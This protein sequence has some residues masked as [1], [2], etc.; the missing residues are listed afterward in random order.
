MIDQLSIQRGVTELHT[1]K[2]TAVSSSTQIHGSCFLI[3]LAGGWQW[4]EPSGWNLGATVTL[5]GI[6]VWSSGDRTDSAVATNN[7]AGTSTVVGGSTSDYQFEMDAPASFTMADARVRETWSLELD[8]TL[9][10]PTTA[11]NVLPGTTLTGA[12]VGPGNT[13]TNEQLDVP[14]VSNSWRCTLNGALGG[15]YCLSEHWW[16]H[17]GI[18]SDRTTVGQSELFVPV[19]LWSATTESDLNIRIFRVIV[20]TSYRF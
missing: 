10:L 19:D 12:T 16:A 3:S 17:A 8:L 2:Q 9:S 18:L 13:I 11:R 7:L 4:W 6:R 14:G 5:P 1:A 15:S 20:G